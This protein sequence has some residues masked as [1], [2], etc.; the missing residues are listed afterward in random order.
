MIQQPRQQRMRARGPLVLLLIL[1]LVLSL[2]SR[3][4]RRGKV[5]TAFGTHPLAL[6]VQYPIAQPNGL[7]FWGPI[8]SGLKGQNKD[9][10]RWTPAG[11]ASLQAAAGHR[12]S[13]K[14]LAWAMEF[15]TF[16]AEKRVG[17]VV[18]AQAPH[19]PQRGTVE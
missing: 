7:V 3:S 13:P 18:Q 16:G 2:S 6:K 11:I 1:A 15:H 4:S 9:S 19:V 12:Q 17:Y 14:P 8:R 10:P 5:T